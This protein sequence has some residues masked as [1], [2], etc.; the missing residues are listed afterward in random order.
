[1]NYFIIQAEWYPVQGGMQDFNYWKFG[2]M[3]VTVEVSC[4]K[5]PLPSQLE[6]YWNDNKKSLIE[7]L[8]L[9]NSGVRGVIRFED[10]TKAKHVTVKIDSRAPYFKTNELGEYYRVLLPGTYSLSVSFDCESVY[11]TTIQIPASTLLL[12]KD[13]ILSGELLDKYTSLSLNRYATFCN[14]KS[15]MINSGTSVS[16]SILVSITFILNLVFNSSRF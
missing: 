11:Q 6:S 15:N 13:I 16:K 14:G 2:C 8:K 4:C 1:M 3:E 10:G 5:Y 7:Y 12:E 9:A